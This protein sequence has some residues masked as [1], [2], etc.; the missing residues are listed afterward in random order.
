MTETKFHYYHPIQ[1]RFADTDAQGHVFFGEY[2]TYFDEAMAAYLK[3]IGFPWQGL[4]KL[5]VDMYYV[6]AGCQFK[7]PS[8]FSEILHVYTRIS[9][10]GNTSLTFELK[11]TKA[12]TG[13]LVATGRLTSVMVSL[14]TGKPVSVPV[15][16]REAVSQFEGLQS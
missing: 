3:A 8:Y 15:A 10:V 14:E 2:F 16:L 5:G 11:I 4:A 13:Q 12:E 7:A 9:R 6:D 1:V